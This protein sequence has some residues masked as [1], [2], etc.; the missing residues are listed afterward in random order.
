ML[1]TRGC[2][3]KVLCALSGCLPRLVSLSLHN[4]NDLASPCLTTLSSFPALRTLDLD[5]WGIRR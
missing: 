2:I 3:G 1:N 5:Y 4:V